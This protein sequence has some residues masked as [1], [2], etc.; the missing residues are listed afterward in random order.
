MKPQYKQTRTRVLFNTGTRIH[1]PQ[2]GKGS[3]K[4]KNKVKEE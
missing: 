3:Y 1:K 4:R 2:K